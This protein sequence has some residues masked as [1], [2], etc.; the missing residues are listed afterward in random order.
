MSALLDVILPVFL[1]IG[2]GYS[3]A[4]RGLISEN[5]VDGIM[6]FAQNFAI[7]CLLFRSIARLDLGAA[8]DPGLMISFY[9]GA[10]L[11]AALGYIG[12]RRIF[13]RNPTD[14]L[15][16]AFVCYFSNTL[17]LGL[18]I[19][20]RAYGAAALSGNYAIISVHSPLLYALGITA[21]ELLRSRGQGK[22]AIALLRQVTRGIF[23]QPLVIG[24]M[25]GIAVNLT[26]LAVPGVVWAAVDMMVG[27]AIP[28]ALFGLGGILLRYRPE[29]DMKTIAMICAISLIVHPGITYL[30]G[31][32][33]FGLN[34]DQM[35]SA[36]ITAAMAPG[37]NAYLFAH[38]YGAARRVAASSVLLATAA[39]VVT[40]WGWLHIL[41]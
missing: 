31:Q 11:A 14:A 7:P 37:V 16:I 15:T 20:E 41:P 8:Y 32:F 9:A 1:V 18:P 4:W 35:R 2:L 5:G 30:L 25:G 24:I 6:R 3:A 22:S 10:L 27:A 40:A 29:G 33:V 39:T 23:L 17:L 36:V 28:A 21:M 12:A 26:G 13:G 38:F 19:T 34:R